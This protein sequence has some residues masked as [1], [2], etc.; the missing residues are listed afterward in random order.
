M[1]FAGNHLLCDT[2]R[3]WDTEPLFCYLEHPLKV[4]PLERVLLNPLKGV[5][6][7]DTWM[8]FHLVSGSQMLPYCQCSCWS[9]RQQRFIFLPLVHLAVP[10]LSIHWKD[11]SVSSR[12]G[13]ACIISSVIVPL[14]HVVDVTLR[15][16][17]GKLKKS[18]EE[19]KVKTKFWLGN[20]ETRVNFI[21]NTDHTKLS[22]SIY[23]L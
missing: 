3:F 20:L 23:N 15:K 12:W 10:L 4:T 2:E 22:L 13:F 5:V 17:W 11:N 14:Q 8:G 7:P 6:N 1:R 19:W 16:V 21:S 18:S 9:L